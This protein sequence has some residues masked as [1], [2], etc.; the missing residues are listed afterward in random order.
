M[1]KNNGFGLFGVIIIIIVTAIVASIATGVIMLNN[2]KTN[3][4]MV[5]K[6]EDLQAFLEFYETIV[7]NYYDDID[8][9]AM[10]DAA[11]K[12]MIDYLGD[13]YTTLLDDSEYHDIVDD[14]KENYT[15]IGIEV[16]NNII[17]SVI[18][19]SPAEKMG[20]QA[21]DIILKVNSIDVTNMMSEEI[22][23]IIKV[24]WR[25]V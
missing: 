6:D 12:G 24:S 23:K 22:A 4:N 25:F 2:S 14:L 1:K 10:F 11:E 21:N 16:S 20:L 18:A 19:N 17:V 9:E 5:S 3:I 7:D 13:K 8:K 15:G